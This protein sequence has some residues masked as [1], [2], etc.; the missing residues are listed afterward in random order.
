MTWVES[1]LIYMCKEIKEIEMIGKEDNQQANCVERSQF[2]IDPK[3][4]I[5][6]T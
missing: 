1:A 3:I 6:T 2:E 4:T 5:P